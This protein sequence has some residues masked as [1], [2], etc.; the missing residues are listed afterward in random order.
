MSHHDTIEFLA[1]ADPHIVK[2]FTDRLLL[3]YNDFLATYPGQ[4]DYID[5]I[6]AVHNLFKVVVGHIVDETGL[7]LWWNIAATT[8]SEA[9]K[10]EAQA[11]SD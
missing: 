2:Q 4:V 9:A 10:K 5:G 6:M 8:F 7:P 1:A 11:N 3:A